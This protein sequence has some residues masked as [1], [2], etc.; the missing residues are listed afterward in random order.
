MEKEI[1]VPIVK[2]KQ[3]N[4]T[5]SV[6]CLPFKPYDKSAKIPALWADF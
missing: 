3:I 5:P 6:K 4:R 1:I 2:I